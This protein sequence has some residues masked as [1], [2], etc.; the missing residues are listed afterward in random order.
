[1]GFEVR[2]VVSFPASPKEA[3]IAKLDHL[4]GEADHRPGSKIVTLSEHVSVGDE[5]DAVEF[6]RG[7]V[8]DAVPAGATIS[9]ITSTPD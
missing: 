1:M 8:I 5:G 2:V 9:E 4:F 7:L 6:V 3:V